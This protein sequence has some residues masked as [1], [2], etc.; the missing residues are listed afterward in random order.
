MS[1][2]ASE[3]R[4]IEPLASKAVAGSRGREGPVGDETQ[5]SRGDTP[6]ALLG[7]N[8]VVGLCA[9]VVRVHGDAD[10]PENLITRCVGNRESRHPVGPP[11]DRPV[12]S[13]CR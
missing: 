5:S 1:Y 11:L 3:W 6:P 2:T 12:Q 13:I 9:A 8:P 10:L 4:S 7:Q